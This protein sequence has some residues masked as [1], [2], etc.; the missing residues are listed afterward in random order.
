[1]FSVWAR[2]DCRDSGCGEGDV[3]GT[4][5]VEFSIYVIGSSITSSK[6]FRGDSLRSK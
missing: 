2:A 3:T 6:R 4:K 1:M 5:D